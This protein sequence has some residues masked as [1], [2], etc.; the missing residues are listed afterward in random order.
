M[1]TNV[2]QC[3]VREV[4]RVVRIGWGGR[5]VGM[6]GIV[7]S[8][9]ESRDFKAKGWQADPPF[10]EKDDLNPLKKSCQNEAE[11]EMDLSFSKMN[12]GVQ[13]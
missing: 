12:R 13:M 3:Y 9:P 5:F 7:G 1:L 8:P 6:P 2:N 11:W 4:T 10:L